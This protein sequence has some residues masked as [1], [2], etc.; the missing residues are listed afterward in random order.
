MHLFA[1]RGLQT[2]VPPLWSL[3][4]SYSYKPT[5]TLGIWCT[6]SGVNVSATPPTGFQEQIILGIFFRSIRLGN[7][8]GAKPLPAPLTS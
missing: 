7:E 8:E 1:L 3:W 5:Y 6:A 4:G 2:S